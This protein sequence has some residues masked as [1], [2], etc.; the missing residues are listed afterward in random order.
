MSNVMSRPRSTATPSNIVCE[1][2][3]TLLDVLRNRLGLTGAKEGCGTGD[4]GACSVML[5]G[6]LVCSCLVL[7]RRGRGQRDRAP[8]KAW[9]RA[10]SCIRCSASSSS[11]RRCNAASAR[12]ASWS[13][14]RRCSTTI[15]NPTET[16]VRFGLAGNL[17]RCTGYDKIVRAVMDA[18]AG[19]AEGLI[20]PLD[21]TQPSQARIHHVVGTRPLRPDGIDKVTGRA[22]FG[23]DA[24]APGMLVGLILRTPACPCAHQEDR[25]RQGREAAG[26]EGGR[27]ARRLP[28]KTDGD[29]ALRRCPGTTSWRAKRRSTTAMRWPRSRRST[30]RIG[31]RG[32]EADQDRLRGAAACDRRRRGDEAR[33]AG[34]ARRRSSP[35]ASSPSPRSRPTSCGAYEFGHGDVEAGFKQA[36]VIVERTFKT[37]ATHQ[38]YIE[39]HACLA[40]VGPD[41]QGEL[42]VC[43]QGHFMV[44]DTCA[45]AA[46]HGHLQAARD[47]LGDRRR[48]RRQD[49]GL[50]RAGGARA[51]AQ[52]QPPGEGGDEPRRGVPGLGPDRRAPRSTSRSA[53]RKDGRI[54]AAEATL[55]Y[56][57][58]AFAGSPV[59]F[60]AMSAFA[61]YDLENVRDVG[62]D[63]V[64][65]RPKQ[66]AYRAP[67]APMAAFAVE[68]VIDELA[69][70]DRHGPDR[71]PH[72]ERGARKARKSSYGPTYGPIGLMRDAGG[73]EEASAL[74]G[75]ARPEPGPRHGLRL[76][77]QFRRP[78]L[79]LAQ[80]QHRRHR[81]PGGRHAGH[82]RL[83]RLDV[84]DG[85]RG[86]RHSL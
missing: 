72:Q 32:A 14:P 17:C 65:N 54:T 39:P 66:A 3:E 78:D 35:T 22:K 57:G 59:E 79:R 43:T 38:G 74:Q 48:L 85:G 31:A 19:N 18:G 12:P 26:R 9:R 45:R 27:H 25:H 13:P 82:R 16:E 73:G 71:L 15:P 33:R 20:M 11:M 5:D 55:R 61:C 60:G 53:R 47:R 21:S 69:E 4:C 67:G 80:H 52:G 42:W 58:G 6:R 37:E 49:H 51:V 70:E 1:A 44:R 28:D 81:R 62:Y 46:R 56:Q 40:N 36:D 86:A 41:G 8:S 30:R 34:A 7:G 75:A 76:L 50:H 63:V 64:T 10:K 84:P 29:A 77:V 68:S 24:T 83:A 2:D 23:A